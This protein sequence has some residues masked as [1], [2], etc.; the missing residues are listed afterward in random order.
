MNKR[1]FKKKLRE[2]TG[3]SIQ[4]NGWTCGTC[5]FSISETL[6]NDDWNAVLNYRGDY[7]LKE[8]NAMRIEDNRKPLTEDQIKESLNKVWELIK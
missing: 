5:F 6:N 1:D 4:H 7:P 8:I 2:A 3:C